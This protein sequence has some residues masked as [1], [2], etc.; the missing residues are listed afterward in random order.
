MDDLNG[1]FASMGNWFILFASMGHSFGLFAWMD[2]W[3]RIEVSEDGPW[4]W[5]HPSLVYN[6]VDLQNFNLES[7]N[8]VPRPQSAIVKTGTL[9]GLVLL[10]A[11]SKNYKSK[12]IS[13]FFA[14]GVLYHK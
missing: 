8:I 4:E 10:L 3:V 12:P 11:H 5:N 14:T 2:D 7:H 6:K 13:N 1:L 9:L